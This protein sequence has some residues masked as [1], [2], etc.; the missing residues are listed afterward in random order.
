M[1]QNMARP[2]RIEFP[3]AFYLVSTRAQPQVR[4]FESDAD[5]EDFLQVLAQVGSRTHWRCQAY[6]LLADRYELLVQ[7]PE[8]NLSRG[9]RQLNGVY[10]QR[11]NERHGRTG[12]IFGGRFKAVVVEAGRWLAPALTHVLAQRAEGGRGRSADRWQLSSYAATLGTLK[13]PPW[14]D[15]AGALRAFGPSPARA[16][17]A[18]QQSLA[19]EGAATAVP[20]AIRGQIFLGSERFAEK[21]RGGRRGARRRPAA[22]IGALVRAARGDEKTAMAR[23]YLSGDYNMGE[24]AR[25][26]GV[27]YSTV[28]RA[29]RAFEQTQAD[30]RRRVST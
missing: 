22:A 21:L 23:A 7:T 24:I 16:R 8:P 10:T 6:C 14:L 30:R 11:F 1:L 25:H 15:L 2:Q 29:V 13:P 5:R 4:A 19:R 26:F 12:Q 28:S 27:H 20:N 3:G 9:M 17:S 18:L